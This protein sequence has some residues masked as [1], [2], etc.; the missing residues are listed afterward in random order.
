MNNSINSPESIKGLIAAEAA[1]R[2]L[3][4]PTDTVKLIFQS[5]FGGAHLVNDY[6][7]VYSR[8]EKEAA[9]LSLN[10]TESGGI[11]DRVTEP[12]GGGSD[13][14]SFDGAGPDHAGLIEFIGNAARINLFHD[15]VVLTKREL[16]LLAH[17]FMISSERFPTGYEN[18]CEEKRGEFISALS[19]ARELAAAGHFSYSAAEFDAYLEKYRAADYPSVSH[20]D[21]YRR[22]YSPAYRVVDS[23]L[24]RIFP[25]ICRIDALIKNTVGTT[26]VVIDGR[27]ASGKTTAAKDISEFFTKAFGIRVGTVHMDDFFLLPEMRTEERLGETGGNLHRER[28]ID[29]VLPNLRGGNVTYRVFDCGKA[30]FSD[31]PHEIRNAKLIICEGAY[32]LHPA[33]GKYYDTAAFSDIDPEQQKKRLLNRN[34]EQMLSRFLSRW[35]PMEEK[36]FSGFGI[37]KRCDIII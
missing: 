1:I 12:D 7:T 4:E 23:R 6:M 13:S 9:K 15:G 31:Q 17:L 3:S 11:P 28:F 35:I 16:E 33:F 29:E 34:G 20:S 24:A 27:A 26:V 2:P 22:A 30:D 25:F 8:L 14:G 10:G 21:A 37:A 18:A 36:Y 5:I 19:Y 32:S